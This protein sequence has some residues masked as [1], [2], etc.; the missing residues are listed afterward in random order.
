MATP[1]AV[2]RPG[3]MPYPPAKM[4]VHRASALCLFCVAGLLACSAD[5]PAPAS[6]TGRPP[7]DAA[8][9]IDLAAHTDTAV[10]QTADTPE[11]DGGD[12]VAIDDGDTGDST[13]PR[14]ADT[15]PSTLQRTLD[16]C[17]DAVDEPCFWLGRFDPA[18]CSGPAPCDKLV[19]LFSGGD[20]GC[21]NPL[22]DAYNR[23]IDAY[24]ADAF[25]F[26][27]AG[28]LITNAA[29]GALP[30]NEEADRVNLLM[31]SITADPQIRQVWTGR[32]L[33]I[34]GASHG[35]TAPVIAMARTA[36]DAQSSW[37]GSRTT[38]ACFYDGSYDAVALD[39]FLLP[40][41]DCHPFRERAICDRYLTG[42]PDYPTCTGHTELAPVA[43]EMQ[44]DVIT[45]VAADAFSVRTWKLIECGSAF[46]TKC[47]V[48]GWD[49]F[50]AAPIETLCANLD[51]SPSHSC[52]LDPMPNNSH[53]LCPSR[54][55][56]IDRCR[57]WFDGL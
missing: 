8:V 44:Q 55:D 51:A 3:S 7:A 27:C 6:D 29:A 26:V 56:G 53:L 36:H 2:V 16:G 49:M 50:P 37:Q 19:I 11:R 10:D 22:S 38:A 57:L 30:Y 25:V 20:M 15:P 5:S 35:A 1:Q 32:D 48:F 18:Q 28:L 13:L 41:A 40:H 39:G 17:R 46:A 23:I 54:P 31:Q 14:D 52:T 24:L 9:G 47:G 42:S 34:S 12:D 45:A 43:S 4:T 33:L 21:D